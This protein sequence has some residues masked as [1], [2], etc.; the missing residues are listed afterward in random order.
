MNKRALV[1][2]GAGFAGS[3]VCDHLLAAGC[4]VRVLD[5]LELQVHGPQSGF[6]IH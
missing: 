3:F 5:N 4:S 1:T 2:G 6:D